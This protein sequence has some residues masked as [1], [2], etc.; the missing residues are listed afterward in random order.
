M[1]EPTPVVLDVDDD[2]EV[3][4]LPAS[5]VA[6]ARAVAPAAEQRRLL[7]TMALLV[8]RLGADAAL[9]ALAE[10]LDR[11]PAML[12]AFPERIRSALVAGSL[13]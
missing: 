10:W 13:P 9:P 3:V 5:L 7:Q 12:A 4:L 11:D 6:K 2:V 1:A 8:V